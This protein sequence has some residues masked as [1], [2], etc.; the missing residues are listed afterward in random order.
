[1]RAVVWEGKPFH[2]SVK[3][4]PKPTIENPGDA[5]I[6]ITTAAICGSD[7][8]TFHGKLGSPNPPWAMGHEGVGIV[9]EVGDAVSNTKVGDWVIVPDIPDNG[10]IELAPP[11]SSSDALYGFGSLFG[12]IGGL[13]GTFE[14][15]YL[16]T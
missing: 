8:H 10:H 9:I 13:Q 1:M 16:Y 7:L 4:I 6:Q 2:V 3:D 14:D 11:P 15:L 12:N 5:I